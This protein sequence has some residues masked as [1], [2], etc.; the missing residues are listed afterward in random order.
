MP[1]PAFRQSSFNSRA[2]FQQLKFTKIQ[3]LVKTLLEK[4]A[5]Q[6]LTIGNF[7]KLFIAAVQSKD[8]AIIRTISKKQILYNREDPALGN[9]VAPNFKRRG[10]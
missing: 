5:A 3:G 8:F 7:K 1:V 4:N 9:F 2:I 6:R 10:G